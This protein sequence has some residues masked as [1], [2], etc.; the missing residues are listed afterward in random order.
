MHHLLVLVQLHVGPVEPCEDVP[1]DEADVV[2][3]DVVAVVSELGAAATLARGVFALGAVGFA[4]VRLQP[5]PLQAG[6][7]L[8]V[9]QRGQLVGGGRGV[10]RSRMG[11]EDSRRIQSVVSKDAMQ[12]AIRAATSTFSACPS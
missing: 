8:V 12:S 1:V 11:T 10:H 3:G 9:Q 7:C 4:T 6:Q 2:A 5:Q